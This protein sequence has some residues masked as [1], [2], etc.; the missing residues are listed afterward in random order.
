MKYKILAVMLAA[1]PAAAQTAVRVPVTAMT[2]MLIPGSPAEVTALILGATFDP[3]RLGPPPLLPNVAA[4]NPPAAA[5]PI[6]AALV[7][8][9]SAAPA[10]AADSPLGVIRDDSAGEPRK[11]LALNQLFENSAP[12]IGEAPAVTA[13]PAATAGD[14]G[15]FPATEYTNLKA[16]IKARGVKAGLEMQASRTKREGRYWFTVN[17]LGTADDFKKIE[18][19]FEKDSA[20]LS[21]AGIPADILLHGIPVDSAALQKAASFASQGP[22]EFS[23][24]PAW[25]DVAQLKFDALMKS[26]GG[27]GIA[28]LRY[29]WRSQYEM[30]VFAFPGNPSVSFKEYAANPMGHP[31]QSMDAS[32][33]TAAARKEAAI[34]LRAVQASRPVAGKDKA[35][36]DAILAFLEGK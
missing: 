17:I 27:G 31:K 3:V 16:A 13:P 35:A 7:R 6:P 18:N 14:I 34:I 24:A 23:Q 26:A 36:L 19:L 22:D 20:G 33:E 8:P 25:F 30:S 5:P 15:P 2:P 29:G 21:Y 28:I 11:T 4:F 9:Y 32:L 10:S 12:S 1:S